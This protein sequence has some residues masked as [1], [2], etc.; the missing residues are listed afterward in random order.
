MTG[1]GPAARVR[2]LSMG[3]SAI[4]LTFAAF[5]GSAAQAAAQSYR[6]DIPAENLG[7]ALRAVGDA[8]QTQMLFSPELVKGKTSRP[9]QGKLSAD[10]ALRQALAGSNLTYRRT[11]SNVILISEAARGAPASPMSAIA[12]AAAPSAATV[13]A[14]TSLEEIVVTGGKRPENVQDVPASVFVATAAAMERAQVRDFDDLVKIAPSLT[15][16]KT[17]Q[18]ANNSINIR[19]VGTYAYSI[20]TESS[21]AV[22]VDDIPQAFQATAFT[23][24]VDVRQI[25][26][27]RG[28]Q[29]TLFGKAASAGV[30]NITTQPATAELSA[31]A[32]VMATDDHEARVSATVSGPVNDTL[33]FRLSG[34]Y[35]DYRG[36][37]YNLGTG[38]WVNGASDTTLRG[39]VVW[40]PAQDWEATLSPYYN[41]TVASCCQGAEYFVSPGVTF[42]K[43]N[44]PQSVILRGITPSPENTNSRMDVDARGNSVDYGAGLRIV[45][46]LGELQLASITSYDR[47]ELHDLQDTDSSD[48]D[49]QTVAPTAPHGGSANGGWF[50]INS[51]TQELRLT[52]P[53]SGRFRYVGG[54]FFSRTGSERFFVRGSNTLGT[55]N[56]L[57]SLPSTNSTAYAAYTSIAHDTNYAV[58]GEGAYAL[59][60]RFDLVGGLR[61]NYEEISYTFRD[62]GNHVT[63]GDPS[64]STQSPTVQISTCNNDT[65]VTGKAGLR[66]RATPNFM[67]FA[68][69]S[70]GYK[71]MA[72]DLTSTLTTRTPVA[73]G[74]LKG[75]PTA[76]AVA[77][78]QPVPPETV[79]SYEL[80]FKASFFDHR[81]VW[82]L[83]VFDEEF[84]GFQA[85][86]R[87]QLTG[88]NILNS[89]GKVYS[90]GVETEASAILTP[91]LAVSL[92]G[93]YD[94]AVMVK[95]P[96]ANCFGAQTAAQGCVGG[97]Q[98]LSGKPLF[99]A[100]RWSVAGNAQY[101]VPTTI[102]GFRPFVSGSFHWQS[103]VIYN[104]LQDPDSVQAAYGIVNLAAG[105]Q[106]DRWK[107]TLFVNNLLDQRYALTRGRDA[108]FNI[109]QTATPPTDAIT[110]KPARDSFR[111][112]GVRLAVSY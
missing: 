77:A 48:F 19:G 49:F 8:S 63:Y 100:P 79:D 97:M 12:V 56:G 32:E 86:S 55:Y 26:I 69:Y 41:H 17:S 13:V 93:A 81:L 50:K 24:L 107:L 112:V 62:L 72:Y 46:H 9:V 101:D 76:D 53:D 90:R 102:A 105:L 33:R 71:G 103:R 108:Q 87:D 70:R 58:F 40:T 104:L 61:V 52:S 60:D 84:R 21:V 78:H 30:V 51:V 18:P 99:N 64:C 7:Q 39:K 110:W 42:G 83:T 43:N 85:Q 106:D 88:Q 3:A 92:A 23:A 4:A 96:N 75:V 45:H 31:H 29:N 94:E 89:I 91:E 82:N 67:A 80:G 5:A 47:Y 6:F 59:V 34:N 68:T 2:R 38:H 35:S 66:Y 37:I 95:F 1:K 25:E 98:D 65:S 16:T 109:S 44:I 57:S 20:A 22:V 10:E 14:P 11:T 111:Y 54:F 36:N 74:P 28:P 15:I 73:S 27:L